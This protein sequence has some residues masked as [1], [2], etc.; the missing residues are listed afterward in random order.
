MAKTFG[1]ESG[2][3]WT[4][5]VYI[6]R[7][8][9]KNVNATLKGNKLTPPSNYKVPE[10]K[11]ILGHKRIALD[12]ETFD[13]KLEEKGPGV[14]RG[15]GHIIGV[16]INYSD[17][18]SRYYPVRHS[19]GDNLDPNRFFALLKEE[20]EKFDGILIN[21]NLQ[22]DLDWLSVEGVEFTNCKFFDV[23][24]AEPL[25]NADRMSYK[26]E[27]LGQDYLGEGK[28]TSVLEAQHGY[29]FIKHLKNIHPHFVGEYACGDVYLPPLIMDKQLP[30]LQEQGLQDLCDLEHRQ[31]P[32]L[33][34]MRRVGVRI[35][36][37]A[38]EHALEACNQEAYDIG[39]KIKDMIGFE[40]DIFAAESIARA[41]DKLGVV[42]PRTKKSGAPSFTKNWLKASLNPLAKLIMDR[43]SLDKTSGTFIRNYMINGHANGRIHCM[44]HPLRSEGGGTISGRYSSSNPNLQNIP[45]RDG[46]LGPM[47]RSIF[48]PEEGQEWGRID[49]SQIEYRFLIHYAVA[50]KCKGAIESAQRYLEDKGMDFHQLAAE[51][52]YPGQEITK[53]LRESAKTINFGVAYGL[54][55]AGLAANLGVSMD[56]AK[57]ILAAFHS[58]IPW[59]KE[60]YNKALN[61]ASS[62]GYIKTI[63]GRR[64]RFDLWEK[65]G[66][67]EEKSYLTQERYSELAETDQ[68][69]YKRARTHKALNALLQG[70]AADLMKKSMVM[71]YEQGL[72][73]ILTPHITVHDELGVSV[74]KTVEGRQAFEQLIHVM[75]NAMKLHVPILASAKTGANWNECK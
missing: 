42:Y 22:Y 19:V 45:A 18:D 7:S 5:E 25:L 72:F 47:C 35:D 11:S 34:Q 56:E 13:P 17:G 33:L 31:I 73:K 8:A 36:L 27:S 37:P 21:A 69:K 67:E 74:P 48:Q 68:R 52:A 10:Y 59:L 38:A 55:V 60:I 62:V 51:I 20:A 30:L 53:A 29:D 12:I 1:D 28:F 50:A 70:S 54:G 75:E 16:A 44:F 32:L 61:Q 4:K 40:V 15:D 58:K 39:N 2:L 23:Q 6:G 57:P 71:A 41:F 26:L 63:L 66:W 14:Y 65:G 46:R 43:R 64:Q 24:Y 9:A 49:W 3:L